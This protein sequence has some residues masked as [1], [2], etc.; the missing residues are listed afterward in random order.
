MARSYTK[1]GDDGLSS[2]G[3]GSRHPKSHLIFEAVGTLDELSSVIG[4]V[5]AKVGE[6]E[7]LKLVQKDLLEAGSIISGYWQKEKAAEFEARTKI[8]EKYIDEMDAKLPALSN[9]IL[10]GGCPA[11]AYM[12]HARTIARR[13]E[14]KVQEIEV[15][16]FSSILV[17]LNRLS[18]YLF[19]RARVENLKCGKPEEEWK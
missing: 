18:S 11:S 4:I 1:L 17:Y 2:F 13:A 16:Q 8:L 10:P 9:F 12:H 3:D 14:R 19:A 6:D 5:K 7:Q 15:A